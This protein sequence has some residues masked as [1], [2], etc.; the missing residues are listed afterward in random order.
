[1]KKIPYIP[2]EFLNLHLGHLQY[3]KFPFINLSCK[4]TNFIMHHSESTILLS[5]HADN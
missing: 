1:M 4:M 2:T 3:F 5:V